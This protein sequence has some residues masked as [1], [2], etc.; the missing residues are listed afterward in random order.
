VW[1][2]SPWCELKIRRS[3]GQLDVLTPGSLDPARYDQIP[4]KWC[5]LRERRWRRCC[6]VTKTKPKALRTPHETTDRDIVS[7]NGLRAFK[8]ANQS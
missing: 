7:D 4:S 2:P 6:G 5:E 8:V 1:I 3:N